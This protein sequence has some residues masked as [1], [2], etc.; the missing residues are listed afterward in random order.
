MT[1]PGID[2]TIGKTINGDGHIMDN[3]DRKILNILNQ[4]AR[5]TMKALGEA[6]GL[7]SPAVQE[8]VKKLEES[9]VITGY[10]ANI[11]YSKIGNY[12]NVLVIIL[13]MEKDLGRFLEYCRQ[14]KNITRVDRVL[15]SE[16]NFIIHLETENPQTLEKDLIELHKFGMTKT[17]IYL[18]TYLENKTE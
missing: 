4:N 18:S 6:V 8:R 1:N 13:V 9:G 15:F 2:V 11:D 5:I 7:T 17:A 10:S 12:M 16:G 14:Q 3:T